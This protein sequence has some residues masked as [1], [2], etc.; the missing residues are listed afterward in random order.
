[1]YFK[2]VGFPLFTTTALP[3]QGYQN[4]QYFW[5]GLLTLSGQK[6][7]KSLDGRKRDKNAQRHGQSKHSQNSYEMGFQTK[8][9][10]NNDPFDPT[11]SIAAS[12]AVPPHGLAGTG[13][14]G[15]HQT[16]TSFT[17]GNSTQGIGHHNPFLSPAGMKPLTPPLSTASFV[18]PTDASHFN[19]IATR[20]GLLTITG[21]QSGGS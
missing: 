13:L 20:I 11:S 14:A 12:A 9:P 4:H 7:V 19:Q 21:L 6:F 10:L 1:M 18:L 2:C 3:D 5:T 17:T 15:F 16:F 8:R